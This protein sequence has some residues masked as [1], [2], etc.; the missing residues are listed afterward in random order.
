MAVQVWL[1][2]S[3]WQYRDWRGRFYP[4]RLPQAEWLEHYAGSFGT[5]E[6]NNSFYRLPEAATFAAWAGRT[7]D[8]FVFAVKASRYLTHIKRLADPE[9]SVDLFMDRAR[10]LGGKLGPVLLQ[11][12]PTLRAAPDRLA[13]TL[14]RFSRHGAQVAVEPRHRSWQSETVHSI[15]RDHNAALVLADRRSRRSPV[16]TTADW[17]YVRLHE[18]SATPRPA[19]GRTALSSWATTLAG[20]D[21]VEAW[22][23][24]NNDPGC[25]A[26]ENARVFG[27][28]ATDAGLDVG[29]FPSAPV[30]VAREGEA[31]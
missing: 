11:L 4:D 10:Y 22:V 16:V 27:R 2:T 23:F 28:L 30:R 19:Y 7:P 21:V 13:R 1:G 6:V 25:W 5:V 29:R 12:P 14:A 9:D 31:A 26:V 8:D 24:F 15:L 20:L 18:G 17:T 3:G